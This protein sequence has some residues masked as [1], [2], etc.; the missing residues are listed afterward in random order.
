MRALPV[1]I[2]TILLS[3]CTSGPQP[4][5]DSAYDRDIAAGRAAKDAF[6]RTPDSPL[7][8]EDRASFTGLAYFPVNALYRMPARLDEDR[9]HAGIIE[10]STSA[11]ER[12]RMQRVG[13]LRFTFGG[14]QHALSAFA[15]EGTITITRLFVPF[16][17]GTSGDTTYAGGRYLDLTRTSTGLYDLDFNHAYNPY[18]VYNIDYV[19]PVPPQ[20]NTLPLHV[21]AGEKLPAG[22]SGSQP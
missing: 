9:S 1:L 19:C 3:A 5:D 7:L 17:D 22:Y 12:R 2:V 15:D 20:E 10:L 16:R 13:L 14:Q 18:C 4:T 8:S 21:L 6:F 11:T